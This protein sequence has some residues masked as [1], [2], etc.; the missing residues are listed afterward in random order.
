M[1]VAQTAKAVVVSCSFAASDQITVDVTVT[2]YNVEAR[3]FDHKFYDDVYMV[4]V[5][6][7][8]GVGDL[9]DEEGTLMEYGKFSFDSTE[10]IAIETELEVEITGV[11]STGIS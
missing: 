7:P 8:K 4:R 9:I 5:T 2:F 1:S 10:E 11:G 3:V 6:K